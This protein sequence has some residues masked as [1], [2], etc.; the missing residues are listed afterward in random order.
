MRKVNKSKHA[1]ILVGI[2]CFLLATVL[3]HSFKGRFAQETEKQVFSPPVV[4]EDTIDVSNKEKGSAGQTQQ[5][6]ALSPTDPV[7]E[8]K[9]STYLTGAV[10]NPGV[11]RIEVESRV[12]QALNAAGGF[13]PNANKEAINL[14]AMMEDGVHI[15]FP[16]K[17]EE[18]EV[19]Q[20]RNFPTTTGVAG[21]VRVNNRANGTTMSL[22]NLNTAEQQ[23]LET[24]PGI[25]P[26]TA[27][28]IITYRETKGAFAR[29]ED[30]MLIKGIG[31]K[32]YDGLKS[33]VT[34][35]K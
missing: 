11:Y 31:A 9:W 2:V 28:A 4:M 18:S 29:V 19:Q 35:A 14:A 7:K 13:A 21:S 10:K 5:L 23:A 33:F 24:I 22:I 26:K 16:R 8:V 27:Q 15:H 1:F 12:Y 25:G 6:V 34:V 3:L 17:G 20:A 32:K 30:L